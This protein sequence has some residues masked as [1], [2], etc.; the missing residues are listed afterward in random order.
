MTTRAW[1]SHHGPAR[2]DAWQWANLPANVLIRAHLHSPAPMAGC[3]FPATEGLRHLYQKPDRTFQPLR[4]P[5]QPLPMGRRYRGATKNRHNTYSGTPACRQKDGRTAAGLLPH[6][7]ALILYSSSLPVF[8][9][10]ASS[11]HTC[12]TASGSV[13]GGSACS[14][15]LPIS[16]D[17]TWMT[18]TMG[19]K[20]LHILPSRCLAGDPSLYTMSMALLLLLV[21]LIFSTCCC[22]YAPFTIRR[23]SGARYRAFSQFPHCRDLPC[24]RTGRLHGGSCA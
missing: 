19:Y 23:R 20:H 17:K 9:P 15:P 1:F 12:Y 3:R 14:P 18:W 22:L 10:G 16:W 4:T 24:R 13:V 6:S 7:P 5:A 2:K 21:L 8:I 11:L